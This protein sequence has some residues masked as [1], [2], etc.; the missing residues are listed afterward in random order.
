LTYANVTAT[1][2]LFIALGGTG[3]A[4]S[5]INGKSI[6]KGTLPATALKK[7]SLTGTQINEGKLKLGKVAS[8]VSADS[9]T[10]AVSADSASTAATVGG[11]TPASLQPRAQFA[12]IGKDATIIEQSGGITIQ[13]YA[14]GQYI[15]NFGT[16]LTGRSIQATYIANAADSGVRST[17][18]VARCGSTGWGSDCSVASVPND[19]RRAWIYTRNQANSA[20]EDHAF[21][22]TVL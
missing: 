1:L 8:A 3:Y 20:L 11:L 16:S 14:D 10:H 7:N 22:I 13:H 12:A 21:I 19:D 2:A 4:A 18:M 5:K 6:K 9:A 17:I 15:V